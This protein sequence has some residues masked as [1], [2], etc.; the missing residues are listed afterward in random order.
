MTFTMT[1]KNTIAGCA[2]MRDAN[3]Q[4]KPCKILL[5]DDDLD[6]RMFAEQTFKR[7]PLIE[8]VTGFSNGLDLVAY[9][10]SGIKGNYVD[11]I[12]T[13]TLIALDLEMPCMNGFQVLKNLK[14]QDVLKDIPVIVLS[15]I[16]TDYRIIKA[17]RLGADGYL[18]KPLDLHRLEA[19]IPMAWQSTANQYFN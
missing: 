15:S 11:L 1:L 8:D 9:L 10:K 12:D 19:F 2:I 18:A 3:K 4:T 16:K 7:S 14:S 5:V 13:P 17:F 6:D